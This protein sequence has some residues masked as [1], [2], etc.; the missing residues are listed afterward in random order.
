MADSKRRK[1]AREKIDPT[2]AY[3]VVG[4]ERLTEFHDVHAVLTEC[5]TNRW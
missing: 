3:L 5:R 1:A 4:V 2:K